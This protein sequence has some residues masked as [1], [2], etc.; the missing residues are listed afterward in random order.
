MSG[1]PSVSIGKGKA[2]PS[3]ERLVE[4]ASRLKQVLG[5]VGIKAEKKAAL[6]AELATL[7]TQANE[8]KASLEGI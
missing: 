1:A 5:K 4:R 2:E 7:T 8:L 6:E 3:P